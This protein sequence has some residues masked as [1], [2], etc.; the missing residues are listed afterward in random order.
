MTKVKTT[1]LY[2]LALL[3]GAFLLTSLT[4]SFL[5][6]GNKPTNPAIKREFNGQSALQDVEYQMSLGPRTPDSKAHEQEVD[7]ILSELKKAGW[8]TSTQDT[9][10][11]GHPVH[12]VIARY[13]QG[14]PWVVLGAHY[15]SRIHA[16]QDPNPQNRLL[17]VPGANDGAS[18]V[19]VLVELGRI[20]PATLNSHPATGQVKAR[21]VWLVFFDSEDNGDIPGWDWLLGSQ[22]FVNSLQGHPDAAVIVDMIGDKQ[23]NIYKEKNSTPALVQEIWGR[24]G[25][26][27][28]ADQFIPQ[29]KYSMI[30]DHTPFLKAG[31]PAV[32]IIDFDFPYWHTT[33]DTVDKVSARSMQTVG[34]V[35]FSWLTR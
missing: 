8:D 33:S 25:Q 31:I 24:A 10:V 26:L 35:L 12:N 30:D 4:A 14:Q 19:A 20:L 9:V 15:D 34:E 13:G 1:N 5:I 29:Y 7:W 22:V 21:Q 18:G 28:H 6:V 16:D 2:R 3:F 11:M 27:G 17:P 32:D 23:L